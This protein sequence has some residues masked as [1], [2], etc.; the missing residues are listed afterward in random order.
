MKKRLDLVGKIVSLC[1]MLSAIDASPYQRGEEI[2]LERTEIKFLSTN[3]LVKVNRVKRSD[4]HGECIK[5][6]TGLLGGTQVLTGAAM[7]ALIGSTVPALGTAI[8]AVIGF[9][10]GGVGG[11]GIGAGMGAILCPRSDNLNEANL[12]LDLG[13]IEDDSDITILNELKKLNQALDV[14][15]LYIIEK[16]DISAK[17]V[18]SKFSIYETD[19]NV[20]VKYLIRRNL[21]DTSLL[22]RQWS[23]MFKEQ[24]REMERQIKEDIPSFSIAQKRTWL[25]DKKSQ[26]RF[27]FHSLAQNIF[28]IKNDEYIKK[29]YHRVQS[30]ESDLNSLKNK[31]EMM[32]NDS[33]ILSLCGSEANAISVYSRYV[34]VVGEVIED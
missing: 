27:L 32:G 31:I 2:K 13:I 16:K 8:G 26:L 5:G 23:T 1:L 15:Y 12:N 28:I 9:L 11:A 10:V 3:D 19:T 21:I 6:T 25:D 29:L 17:V 20:I 4:V 18:A 7:G 22:L 30:L 34:P 14:N 33:S 24:Q